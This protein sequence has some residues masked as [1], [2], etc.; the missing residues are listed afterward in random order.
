[1][2]LFV[3]IALLF[4]LHH[5]DALASAKVMFNPKAF[6][7]KVV[8]HIYFY[9]PAATPELAKAATDEINLY[10]NGGSHLGTDFLTLMTAVGGGQEH[11][12]MNVTSEVVTPEVAA[13]LQAAHP[14]PEMNFIQ[15]LPGNT[16]AGDRSFMD[17]ICASTGTWYAS[18]DLGNSTTAAH[19]FGHGLCLN[20][21]SNPY[22]QGKG[23]PAIMCPRGTLVDA[24]YQYDPHATA[25]GPG[26][27]MSPYKRRVIQFDI[28]A[29][30][31]PALNYDQ[32]GIAFLTTGAQETKQNRVY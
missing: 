27:T 20:H 28:D 10:W 8:A 12:K 17:G 22:W 25:G 15:L 23:Q 19:E 21:P 24:I 14:T 5:N 1:M 18:D 6:S 4:G 16:A 11:F 31:L 32:N 3:L 13:Q 30:N 26:G 2:K 29:M 7:L 9:G